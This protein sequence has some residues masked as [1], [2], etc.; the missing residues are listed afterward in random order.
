M[1]HLINVADVPKYRADLD[2]DVATEAPA[3][4]LIKLCHEVVG[5]D[6]PAIRIV[7]NRALSIPSKIDAGYLFDQLSPFIK[8]LRSYL[9]K[10]TPPQDLSVQ[11][12]FGFISDVVSAL[13]DFLKGKPARFDEIQT[14]VWNCSPDFREFLNSPDAEVLH[15]SKIDGN[16]IQQELQRL[17]SHRL[18]SWAKD[19]VKK[20]RLLIQANRWGI[21][22]EKAKALWR[23][24]GS[25]DVLRRVVG[26][27]LSEMEALL[28]KGT[29]I[30]P[31]SPRTPSES[32]TH[33][34]SPFPPTFAVMPRGT[35][36]LTPIAP[37]S[38]N[39]PMKRT[40]SGDTTPTTQTPHKK[41]RSEEKAIEIGDHRPPGPPCFP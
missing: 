14:L 11:P 10:Q 34:S 27:N 20:E 7:L 18:L 19:A 6:Q 29:P 39:R 9:E 37:S 1:P 40:R 21:S 8:S 30:V 4:H 41:K 28:Q 35:A 2:S 22:M 23:S 26:D 32:R 25:K 13:K 15:L 5:E 24:I 33:S 17:V 16:C 12:Y 31:D 36:T 3:L 38:S